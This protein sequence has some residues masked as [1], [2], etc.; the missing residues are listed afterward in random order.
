MAWG[1]F[2]MGEKSSKVF[3]EITELYISAKRIKTKSELEAVE[4]NYT[5]IRIKCQH[6]N[7]YSKMNEIWQIIATKKEFL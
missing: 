7:H 3:D 5:I 2:S 4:D 1:L 6:Q